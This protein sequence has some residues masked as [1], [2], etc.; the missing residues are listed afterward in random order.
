VKDE[1]KQPVLSEFET[2]GI[3]PEVYTISV[4]STGAIVKLD[5]FKKKD[6]TMDIGVVRADIPV[7]KGKKA[8]N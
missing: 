4:I 3:P 2:N 7:K 5:M 8:F 6:K 1:G